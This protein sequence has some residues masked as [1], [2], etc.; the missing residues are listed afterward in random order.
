MFGLRHKSTADASVPLCGEN[1]AGG[2]CVDERVQT[3]AARVFSTTANDE[4]IKGRPGSE[5]SSRGFPWRVLRSAQASVGTVRL[6]AD[7]DLRKVF[8]RFPYRLRRC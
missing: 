7:V 4:E 6:V 1:S 5:S 3:Q 8:H 2:L